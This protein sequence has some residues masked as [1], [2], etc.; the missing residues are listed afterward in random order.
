MRVRSCSLP[1]D[2]ITCLTRL[3]RLSV[4]FL[5]AFLLSCG[6]KHPT[7]VPDPTTLLTSQPVSQLPLVRNS[8]RFAVIGDSGT[9]KTRQYDVAAVLTS[10][11]SVFPFD[12]VLMMG[13]NI[14]GRERDKDYRQKF[15]VPY[16]AL[17]EAGVRFYACRGNHD[18]KKQI[19]YPAFNMQGHRYYTFTVWNV[20]FFAL[21][22]DEFDDDEE[23]WIETQLRESRADWKIAFFHHP[24]YS[25]GKRHGSSHRLR[26][27]LEPLFVRYRV[28]VVFSGHDHVYERLKPQNGVQYFVSGA[29]GQ[30]RRGNVR[31]SFLQAAVFDQD[32]SFMLLEIFGDTFYFQA[33]SRTGVTVDAGS[34]SRLTAGNKSADDSV[35]RPVA[36]ETSSVERSVPG[37]QPGPGI[38]N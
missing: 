7:A 20:Q 29:A 25:S 11:R 22:T 14:Y 38:T 21:D 32:N 2:K 28:N 27:I 3:R 13:D 8:V 10:Y 12:F 31:K 4:L 1:G 16:Q 18:N 9:G 34:L 6:G 24:I 37:P 23:A 26:K 35:S 36:P 19:Y 17:L 5:A 33:V 30:L 15:E